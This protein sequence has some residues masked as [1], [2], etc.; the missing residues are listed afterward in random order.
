MLALWLNAFPANFPL[1]HREIYEVS[2]LKSVSKLS[3][4][5]IR[6]AAYSGI[7]TFIA[8]PSGVMARGEAHGTYPKLT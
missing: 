4:S 1:T 5:I 7:P 6:K 3:T 2:K 8:K